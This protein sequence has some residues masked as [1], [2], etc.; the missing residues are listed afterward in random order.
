MIDG[1]T[2][3]E[4]LDGAAIIADEAVDA[5][6]VR[7]SVFFLHA[8]VMVTDTVIVMTISMAAERVI[9]D[10]AILTNVPLLGEIPDGAILQRMSVRKKFDAVVIGAGQSG[11][12][13]AVRLA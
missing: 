5:L 12:S 9:P 13:L 2:T 1:T 8:A 4:L 6:V 3:E 11:P 7:S 10:N